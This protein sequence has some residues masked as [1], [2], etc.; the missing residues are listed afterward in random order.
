MRFATSLTHA[1]NETFSWVLT[2]TVLQ[3]VKDD[4][5][6][7]LGGIVDLVSTKVK[8]QLACVS[9]LSHTQAHIL[10]QHLH[11]PLHHTT[12]TPP[13][14]S[15]LHHTSSTITYPLHFLHHH[16]PHLLHH[17]FSLLHH[18]LSTTL[19]PLSLLHHTTSTPWQGLTERIAKRQELSTARLPVAEVMSKGKERV[20]HRHLNLPL[21]IG[22]VTALVMLAV[23]MGW[24]L[25]SCR[26]L[27]VSVC[28]RQLEWSFRWVPTKEKRLHS[29][30]SAEV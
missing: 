11:S 24:F 21:N 10:T 7:V 9:I 16:T 19:P 17:H 4:Q 27:T 14:S 28:W 5:I 8:V 29:S 22:K 25:A 18:H 23:A 2:H 6:Y 15:L 13:P 12:S 1:N 26:H 20:S 3:E 30:L